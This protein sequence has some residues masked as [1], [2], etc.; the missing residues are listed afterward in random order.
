MSTTIKEI[1]SRL[2][3]NPSTVSRA[4]SGHPQVAEVTRQRVLKTA[5]DMG[6]TPNLWAQNLVGSPTHLIGCLVLEFS[7]P[8][9]IPMVRAIE[10]IASQ[11]NHVVFLGE[12]RRSL[13][14]EKRMIDRFL[15]IR[16]SGMIITPV[17]SQ[18]DHL[19]A[20]E[21]QGVPIVVAGRKVVGFNSVDVDNVQSGYLAGTFLIDQGYQRIGFV[22]SGDAFNLPEQERLS[23]LKRRLEEEDRPIA[24]LYSVK[25]NRI[26]GGELAAEM[27]LGQDQ[28]PDAL[29]CSN[30]LLAMGFIQAVIKK[31]VLI[32]DDV[33]VMG[34]DDIPFASH[35]I[36][37]LT[38]IAYPKYELGQTAITAL[39]EHIAAAGQ[40]RNPQHHK[41]QPDLVIRKS[42]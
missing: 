10:D 17:L 26:S 1:A 3:L 12:S 6:Y 29:F 40:H 31:R 27:W 34:H 15:R 4:L 42:A 22:H 39:L 30:D 7:N 20:L 8:F 32:P 23:G 35:F 2:G 21:A 24:A 25:N 14:T 11:E 38:T 13:D 41:L 16:V 19:E 37:P 33:A 36:Q 28:R 5:T 18:L 9:Y